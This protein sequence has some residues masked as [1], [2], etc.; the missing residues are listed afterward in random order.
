MYAT[1]CDDAGMRGTITAERV[2]LE[3]TPD[4]V[5]LLA[6]ALDESVCIMSRAEFFIRVGGSS[7]NLSA[8]VEELWSMANGRSTGFEVALTRGVEA[9][10]NP[11]R[12]RPVKGSEE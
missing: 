11:R 10:E 8:V 6:G 5:A 9:E 1:A 4:E 12:P 3:L 2:T 7:P